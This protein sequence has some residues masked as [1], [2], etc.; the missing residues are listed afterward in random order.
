MTL[1][2]FLKTIGSIAP[3]AL[4]LVA[5]MWLS[6]PRGQAQD[7]D[8][9]GKDE[10]SKIEQGLKIA[11]VKLNLDD[12]DRDLV[13]L[14]SYIVNAQ[15]DCAG[16]HSNPEFANGGNPYFKDQKKKIDPKAYLGG[17][18]DFGNFGPNTPNIVSRNLTPDKT[19]RPEGGHT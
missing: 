15:G 18:V 1:Q 6:S 14:G 10:E 3:V 5:G 2:Q 11:P 8:D 7:Q 16:C 9:N 17:G 13:G 4:V 19:G 12:K